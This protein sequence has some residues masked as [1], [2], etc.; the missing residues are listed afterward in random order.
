M[1]KVRKLDIFKY[2]KLDNDREFRTL[3]ILEDRDSRLRCQL[4]QHRLPSK[5]P[6]SEPLEYDAISWYWGG[7]EELTSIVVV[8]DDGED[9]MLSVRP[10]LVETLKGLRSH[11][12]KRFW[13][14]ALCINQSDTH[15]RDLQVQHMFEI[16]SY[17]QNVCIWLGHHEN[18]SELALKFIKER[19]CDLGAFEKITRD[20]SAKE[21]WKALAALMNRPWFSRRWGKF[22]A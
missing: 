5:F 1:F 2:R 18:H 3:T 15:E 12:F 11:G 20:E 14:D 22:F 9:K 6:K 13:I 16:Y 17:A 10:N 4:T 7:D 19:V 21:E 8:G